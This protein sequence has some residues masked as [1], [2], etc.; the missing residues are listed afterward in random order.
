[1]TVKTDIFLFTPWFPHLALFQRPKSQY[2]DG[3][4]AAIPLFQHPFHWD[5]PSCPG[6]GISWVMLQQSVTVSKEYHL[7]IFKKQCEEHLCPRIKWSIRPRK[8]VNWECREV[9]R[10]TLCT[11][12][13]RFIDFMW[14]FHLLVIIF[15]LQMQSGLWSRWYWLFVGIWF[16]CEI[17][18]LVIC[19]IVNYLADNLVF[20]WSLNG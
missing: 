2:Q 17:C 1:M 13:V 9:R 7:N 12:L 10:P 16:C 20:V 19:W 8:K 18:F 14:K 11:A 4:D 5:P 6:R 15:F 3:S